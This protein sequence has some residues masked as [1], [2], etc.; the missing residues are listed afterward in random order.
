MLT[1]RDILASFVWSPHV[2]IENKTP[3]REKL[4]SNLSTYDPCMPQTIT[5]ANA[6]VN[7]N[8]K[9]SDDQTIGTLHTTS[10]QMHQ[11]EFPSSKNDRRPF[12]TKNPNHEKF[13]FISDDENI[14]CSPCGYRY[15]SKPTRDQREAW[16]NLIYQKLG[17]TKSA[18][19]PK[20]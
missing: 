7:S 15:P 4:E 2:T 8:Y 14:N 5:S 12:D 20:N 1:L 11:G 3:D 17:F 16:R 10:R 13:S 9:I 19:G 18:L 6:I